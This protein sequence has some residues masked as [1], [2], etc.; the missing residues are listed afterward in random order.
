[1][2]IKLSKDQEEDR[3]SKSRNPTKNLKQARSTEITAKISSTIPITLH[4]E[5]SCSYLLILLIY[6][7]N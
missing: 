1:M 7:D 2:L 4:D 5:S 3:P 6:F